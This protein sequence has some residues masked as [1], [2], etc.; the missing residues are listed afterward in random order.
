MSIIGRVVNGVVVLPP[1]MMLPEGADVK[2]ETIQPAI[3]DDPFTSAVKQILIQRDQTNELGT[4]STLPD[5]MAAN[6][7]YY[8]HGHSRK[9][10][11]RSGRWIGANS[12]AELTEQ[13]TADDA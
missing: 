7:D 11:P 9:Q 8:L 4:P 12:S 3:A 13:Q 5:D 1:G 2:V 6:L 10:Q